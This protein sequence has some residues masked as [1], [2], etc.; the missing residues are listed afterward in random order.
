MRI[1]RIELQAFGPFAGRETVDLEPLNDAGL[2]LLDG[3]TGA[4]KSTVLSAVCFAL[5]GSIPGRRSVDTLASTHAAPGTR[6]E[7]LLE[8]TLGGRRF[9]ILRWPKYLRPRKRR[10]SDGSQYT[11]EKAG[12]QLRELRDGT[13]TELSVRADE[14]GQLLGTVLPLDSEQFMHVVMLPQGEFARFLRADSKDKEILLRRLFGTGRFDHVEK[15]LAARHQLLADAVRQ[16]QQLT[17]RLREEIDQA[18]TRRLGVDWVAVGED[19]AAEEESEEANSAT[20]DRTQ[21]TDEDWS[22]RA[23]RAVAGA[24]EAAQ[25]QVEAARVQAAHAREELT[26]LET[27]RT[28]VTAAVAWAERDERHRAAADRIESSRDRLERH[29]MAMPLVRRARD[30][31]R[32][33]GA[34]QTARQTWDEAVA[35]ARGEELCV[36][37]EK[38]AGVSASGGGQ[39]GGEDL[40][41]VVAGFR[42]VLAQ[43]DRAVEAA[44]Q[45]V[46]D[47][48]RAAELESEL[49]TGAQQDQEAAARI[50]AWGIEIEQMQDRVS[51]LQESAQGL[52]GTAAGLDQAAETT[53]QAVSRVTAARRMQE[54]ADEVRDAEQSL[55]SVT[56]TAQDTRQHW[57]DLVQRRLDNAAA[58][59]A[60][61]LV[62]DQPCPVCGSAEHPDPS[63]ST[64]PED[65]EDD[66]HHPALDLSSAA[67]E[68]AH[69]AWR[70]AETR[71]EQAQRVLDDL[72]RQVGQ[73]QVAAAGLSLHEAEEQAA[74]AQEAQ[75]RA[76][77]AASELD[78]TQAQLRQLEAQL[79]ERRTRQDQEGQARAQLQTRMEHQGEERDR[80]RRQISA[81]LQGRSSLAE[82]REELIRAR[83][84]V[85]TALAAGEDLTLR[86]ATVSTEQASLARDIA[87]SGYTDLDHARAALLDE[88][89]HQELSSAV[90]AWDQER[91]ALAELA[92]TADVVQGQELLRQGVAVPEAE[93]IEAARQSALES[94]EREHAALS[95]AGGMDA[96]QQQIDQQCGTLQEVGA[97]SADQRARA[98][99]VEELLKLVRG[100]GENEYSMRLASYVLTGRLEDVAQAAT[101]RLLTMTDGRY[102]LVHDDSSTGGARRRGLDL[103][104]RDLYTDTL[105]PASSLSGGETFMASLALALGLADTVQAEAGGVEMDTLFVDEGFGSLDAQTLEQVM[106][107]LDGLQAGGRTLGLVSHV[108]RMRQEIPCRLEVTKTR[109]GS[110]L[111]VVLP[112]G[113]EDYP[114]QHAS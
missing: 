66:A 74:A 89:L 70:T 87:A 83:G 78:R 88:P 48:R 65:T 62:P 40:A 13:W 108:D 68:R 34:A 11:E 96:L 25:R 54:L 21:W 111:T 101:E 86:E 110:H 41:R 77:L 82:L 61:E 106:E 37:W 51:G 16:D 8:V 3:P 60:A 24:V 98:V 107:V 32:A 18:L 84:R 80:L 63:G 20:F 71:R 39:E 57:L 28:A 35:A 46:A 2:F 109:Q 50:E 33:A 15:D 5:Y 94:T 90:Q 75:Q 29:R 44:D 47:D 112:T 22:V 102:E 6:P 17:D 52:T 95:A 67:Q 93:Q 114:G 55:R 56:D 27:H 79:G 1:H 9:E 72:R 14:I 64:P 49:S 7:V 113:G 69:D 85:Q 76:E 105:R 30:V 81:A 4:G 73:T 92:R 97:R 53:A 104:V 59:L 31:E 10:S 91:A 38:A 36:G 12:A 99:E 19:E 23:S 26:R 43:A 58:L 103:V 45:H 100:G 42:D